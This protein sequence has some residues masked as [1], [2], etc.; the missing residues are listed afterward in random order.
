VQTHHLV[1]PVGRRGQ[2]GDRDRR[3]VG[4]EDGFLGGQF[5]EI[6]KDALLELLVLGGRLDDKVTIR[7]FVE[8]G[9]TVIRPRISSRAASSSFPR[10]TARSSDFSIRPNA[11]SAVV[12][13]ISWTTTSPPARA[14]ISAIPEPINPPPITPTR[15]IAIDLS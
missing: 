13:S 8:F 11:A 15:S 7:L 14:Q 5:V 12:A 4:G 1:R 10:S 3:G 2:S 6:G 9:V